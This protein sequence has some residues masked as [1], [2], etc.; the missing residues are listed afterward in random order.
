[1]PRRS[2]ARGGSE[3]RRNQRPPACQ[4]AHA[5]PT[6]IRFSDEQI[7][8]IMQLARPLTP[9][10]RSRFLE[11]LVARLNGRGEVGDGQLYQI[12]RELQKQYF[13][14]PDFGVDNGSYAR[15]RRAR[16]G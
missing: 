10:Q 9:D 15:G 14:P 12:C 4:R 1:M 2:G 7:T 8:S 16:A 6:P 11:M 3:L 5:M 13:A